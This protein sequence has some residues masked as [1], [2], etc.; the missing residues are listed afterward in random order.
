MTGVMLGILL[1]SYLE[2]RRRGF[3]SK[4]Q[5]ELLFGTTVAW[6]TFI[7]TGNEVLGLLILSVITLWFGFIV[8]DFLRK[9][10]R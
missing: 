9:R 8:P 1:I 10:P 6:A 5:I 2:V 7:V 4:T 3:L